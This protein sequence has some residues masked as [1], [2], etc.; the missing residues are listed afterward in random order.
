[1]TAQPLQP[2]GQ[3]PPPSAQEMVGSQVFMLI[4]YVMGMVT[5]TRWVRVMVLEVPQGSDV[6][7]TTGTPWQATV[8]V[9]R[10]AVG[11]RV[12]GAVTSTHWVT[13]LLQPLSSPG[14]GRM[15]ACS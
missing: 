5:Q 10:E 11:T 14:Q 6:Q 8:T 1:M 2:Q 15:A 4:S 13:I 3:E 12:T 9:P 7:F